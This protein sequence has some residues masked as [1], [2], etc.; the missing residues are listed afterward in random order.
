MLNGS[1]FF[2]CIRYKIVYICWSSCMELLALW[3]PCGQVC[4]WGCAVRLGQQIASP[5]HSCCAKT[6]SAQLSIGVVLTALATPQPLRGLSC[7]CCGAGGCL[8]LAPGR[9][10]PWHGFGHSFKVW[11]NLWCARCGGLSYCSQ[12]YRGLC[13]PRKSWKL[14]WFFF[15]SWVKKENW[16]R[17]S[18]KETLF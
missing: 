11:S 17:K 10:L 4:C 12:L 18:Q 13:F 16:F 9:L 7:G 14:N 3:R 1:G 8:T 2:T 5:A 6:L 15:P